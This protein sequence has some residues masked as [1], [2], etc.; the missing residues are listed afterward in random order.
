MYKRGLSHS[1]SNAFAVDLKPFVKPHDKPDN[2]K[3]LKSRIVTG[4]QRYFVSQGW[5]APT[6]AP[7]RSLDQSMSVQEYPA[8]SAGFAPAS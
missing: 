4:Q 7:I 8:Q 1:K 2:L 5:V 3:P 6:P